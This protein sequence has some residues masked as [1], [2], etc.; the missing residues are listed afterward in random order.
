MTTNLTSFDVTAAPFVT[1]LAGIL[2]VFGVYNLKI[3]TFIYDEV[4][5]PVRDVPGPPSPSFLYI[6][7]KELSEAVSPKASSYS[8]FSLTIPLL[9]EG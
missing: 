7:L 5:S 4:T 1:S 3:S 9:Q 8:D 2:L 6:N